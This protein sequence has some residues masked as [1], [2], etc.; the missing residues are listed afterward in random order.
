MFIVI[1]F[2]NFQIIFNFRPETSEL[3][4]EIKIIPFT[5]NLHSRDR[6]WFVDINPKSKKIKKTLKS[7]QS[8]TTSSDDQSSNKKKYNIVNSKVKSH[9]VLDIK[10]GI[11]FLIDWDKEIK[12]L[13]SKRFF[14]V[15]DEI[16]LKEYNDLLTR[17]LI[18]HV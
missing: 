15:I 5:G 13:S 10:K 11:L 3:I 14:E 1:N 8:Q 4:M 7:P 18:K 2:I 16:S 17:V 9:V 6:C 12:P